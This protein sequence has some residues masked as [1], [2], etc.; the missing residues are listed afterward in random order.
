MDNIKFGPHGTLPLEFSSKTIPH[1]TQFHDSRISRVLAGTFCSNFPCAG[2]LP[3]YVSMLYNEECP[4]YNDQCPLYN[5][6]YMLYNVLVQFPLYIVKCLLYNVKCTLYIFQCPM[7]IV[8]CTMSLY[9][10]AGKSKG[11]QEPGSK[12]IFQG[13][14]KFLGKSS[15]L[16]ILKIFWINFVQFHA[17]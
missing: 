3:T 17:F 14:R 8:Q 5:E 4:L 15:F 12:K 10:R 13:D 9:N 2:T 7:S 16:N 6:K 1:M 11:T